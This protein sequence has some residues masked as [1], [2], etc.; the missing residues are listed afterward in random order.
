MKKIIT[1][2]III[3]LFTLNSC[4]GPQKMYK[5][6]A[7]VEIIYTDG[8]KDDITTIKESK[9]DKSEV[10]LD[11]DSGCAVLQ[12]PNGRKAVIAC[13]IRKV[14]LRSLTITEIVTKDKPKQSKDSKPK[15]RKG[16]Q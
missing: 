4:C 8:T 16:I 1:F 11:S 6:T 14:M 13:D 10:M 12:M 2:A 7:I 9:F 5:H 15:R 3:A